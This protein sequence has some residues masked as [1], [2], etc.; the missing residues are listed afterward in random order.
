MGDKVEIIE[1]S[2]VDQIVDINWHIKDDEPFYL[3]EVNRKKNKKD[4]K[5]AI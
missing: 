3:V 1:K 5:S 4:I 2:L